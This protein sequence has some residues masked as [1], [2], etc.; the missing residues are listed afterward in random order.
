MF[1]RKSDDKLRLNHQEL[2]LNCIL[3]IDDLEKRASQN[4]WDRTKISF[5]DVWQHDEYV[6]EI[7]KQIAL[8]RSFS[9]DIA[10]SYKTDKIKDAGRR[11]EL[12]QKIIDGAELKK[13]EVLTDLLTKQVMKKTNV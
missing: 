12:L 8:A 9:N 6:D 11:L 13:H 4:S 3:Q 5:E 2:Y 1:W 10:D 7:V